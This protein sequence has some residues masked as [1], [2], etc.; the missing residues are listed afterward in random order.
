MTETIKYPG[1]KQSASTRLQYNGSVKLPKSKH[2]PLKWESVPHKN[3]KFSFSE[4][5]GDWDDPATFISALEKVE[6]W[7]FSRII[8]YVWWQVDSLF[9]MINFRDLPCNLSSISLAFLDG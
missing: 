5:F 7:I 6:S 2:S 1:T 9:R 4:S 3:E 8:E